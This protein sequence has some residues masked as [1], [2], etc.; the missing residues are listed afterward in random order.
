MK[1]YVKSNANNYSG[2]N[3]FSKYHRDIKIDIEFAVENIFNEYQQSLGINVGDTS[4]EVEIQSSI[5][6]LA[7]ALTYALLEQK[8]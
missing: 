8:G 3:E 1:R 7:T 6:A 5:D 4:Y 2:S